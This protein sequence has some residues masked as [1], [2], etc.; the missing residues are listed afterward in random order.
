MEFKENESTTRQNVW[1]TAKAGLRGKLKVTN[2][3]IKHRKISN[4][5]LNVASETPRK[6]RT[7]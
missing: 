1:N 6:I 7:S 3:Y 4:K 5:K 2:A